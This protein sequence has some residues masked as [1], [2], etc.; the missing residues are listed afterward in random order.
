MS[1]ITF[2]EPFNAKEMRESHLQSTFVPTPEFRNLAGNWNSLLVGP[3]GSGKTTYLRM[4]NLPALRTWQHLEAESYRNAI[5][6]VGIYVPSDIAW[7]AMVEALG[8]NRLKPDCYEAAAIAAFCT[9]VLIAGVE[10][11]EA[12][13]SVGESSEPLPYNGAHLSAKGY[14]EAIS[15]IAP[16]WKLPIKSLSFSGLHEALG[17]RLMELSS[18]A[19]EISADPN[20]TLQ[21][22]YRRIPY[23][24]LT[25]DTALSFALTLLDRRAGDS[26][27]KWALLL[28]EFEIASP[29]IH[30]LV[31]ASFRSANRKLLYKVALAPCGPHTGGSLRTDAIPTKGNDFRSV[32][33]WYRDKSSTLQF[34]NA[35]FSARFSD[36]EQLKGKSP[37]EM[38]G[39][40][41]YGDLD[42]QT[43]NADGGSNWASQW[44]K[45]FLELQEKDASFRA[46]LNT[47]NIDPNQL[48]SSDSLQRKIAPIVA[49]RNAHRRIEGTVKRK[50]RKKLLFA[51]SGW[52]A[53]AAITEGNPRWFIGV[54]NLI[55]SRIESGGKLPIPQ[56][57][58]HDQVNTASE[59]FC[60]M[61]RTAAL[62]QARG[63]SSN[64]P[65]FSLL[66][67][68]G[69]YF[70]RRVI[71]DDFIEEIPLSFEVDAKVDDDTENALR[72]AFNLG[73][74]VCL[75]DFEE[76][77]STLKGL[78]FRL[79][80]LLAPEFKLPLRSTKHIALSSIL[81]EKNKQTGRHG[82][83]PSM[84][85]GNL[86]LW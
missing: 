83:P 38:L 74:I 27:R 45:E 62:E 79:A 17:L 51:Y 35:L 71:D 85:Q 20:H 12:R 64:I 61:L 10:A 34:C 1:G 78:R 84:V 73:A 11:M 59:S 26:D 28:D 43:D 21:D 15:E 41:I 23:A 24:S 66:E 8:N 2:L 48:D 29:H 36:N 76:T 81:T 47:K 70:N 80:Y 37:V 40:S 65:V 22:L 69:H 72:V 52:E 32:H 4:L 63:V 57:I 39:R 3:R 31:L 30:R 44:S 50:G 75:S 46:F 77:S 25:Y 6:Y 33:L 86:S 5:N 19:A 13:F 56:T 53:V 68:I 82:T 18:L 49:F 14:E 54:L 67:T 9:N 16:A 55:V 42:D 58:Q 7:G 60:A